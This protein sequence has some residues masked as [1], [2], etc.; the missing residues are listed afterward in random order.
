MPERVPFSSECPKCG[1]ERVQ[2]GYGG[3]ELLEL[4][5]CGADIEAYCVGCDQS[6]VISVEERADLERALTRDA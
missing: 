3:E 6:W 5:R 2:A 1:H 4:L